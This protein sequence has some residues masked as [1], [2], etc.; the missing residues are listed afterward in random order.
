MVDCTRLGRIN[1]RKVL[2]IKAFLLQLLSAGK[3][4]AAGVQFLKDVTIAGQDAVDFSHHI[5]LLVGLFVIIAIAARV[6]AEFLVHAPNDGFAAIETF[7]FFFFHNI[8][9]FVVQFAKVAE[10]VEAPSFLVGPSTG[11]GT[12]DY[13]I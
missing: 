7:L 13:S 4:F 8:Q 12:F 5:D 11:S 10:L 3:A 6:A 9:L 1:T 2:E